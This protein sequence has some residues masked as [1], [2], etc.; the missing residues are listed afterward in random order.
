MEEALR[1]TE[2]RPEIKADMGVTRVGLQLPD[3]GYIVPTARAARQAS[4]GR[5]EGEQE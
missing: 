3:A 1:A 5:C 2:S 4:R